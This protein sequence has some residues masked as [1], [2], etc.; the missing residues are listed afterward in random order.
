MGIIRNFIDITGI[1]PEEELPNKINGEIVQYS[2]VDYI[3]VPDNKQEISSIYQIF[4]NIVIKSSRTINAPLGKIV[5]LDGIKKIK[6]IYTEKNETDKASIL[7]LELPYNTFIELP[8]DAGMVKNI[9]VN[10]V[11][12]YFALIDSK[13]IYSNI[14]YMLNVNYDNNST[15]KQV[16]IPKEVPKEISEFSNEAHNEMLLSSINSIDDYESEP[17][18]NFQRNDLIMDINEEYL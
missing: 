3:F 12:A 7:N 9:N 15:E 6:L 8:K 17:E 14:L 18:K 11:D 2:E 1:T 10:I 16:F 5:V 4:I 13:K